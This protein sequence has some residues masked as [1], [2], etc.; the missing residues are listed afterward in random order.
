MTRSSP[1]HAPA[2][3]RSHGE[4]YVF[5]G[6]PNVSAHDAPQPPRSSRE[7]TRLCG[8]RLSARC[9]GHLTVEGKSIMRRLPVLIALLALLVPILVT[10]A[11]LAQEATPAAMVPAD[12]GLPEVAITIT[13]TGFDAPTEL[14]AGRV[15]LT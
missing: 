8:R 12:L 2:M 9:V 7:T 13:D 1:Q 3:G 6:D 10:P 11:A 14:P 4:K 5:R 15:L